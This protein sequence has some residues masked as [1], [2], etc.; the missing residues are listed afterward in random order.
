MT[1]K[2]QYAFLR[3]WAYDIDFVLDTQK[4]PKAEF[5]CFAKAE[6]WNNGDKQWKIHREVCLEEAYPYGTGSK[7]H[8]FLCNHLA[9]L[10][11]EHL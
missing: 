9:E 7:D 4:R 11:T 6:G 10:S 3:V 8:T 2:N 5:A 1:P